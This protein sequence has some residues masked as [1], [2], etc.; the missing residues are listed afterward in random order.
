MAINALQNHPQE[1]HGPSPEFRQRVA[2]I[3]GVAAGVA[4]L[5]LC[6]LLPLVGPAASRGSGSP[7][8]VRAAHYI[9]NCIAFLSGWAVTS[10]LTGSA[11][12]LFAIAGCPW[13]DR[14]LLSLSALALVCVAILVAFVTGA[15]QI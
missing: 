15:L 8:A 14:R 11:I 5:F 9:K 10:A 2:G 4:F 7:G 13:R 1:R 6:M 12:Y 3:L